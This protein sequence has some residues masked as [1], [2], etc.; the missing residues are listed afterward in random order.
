ME[1]YNDGYMQI[2]STSPQTLANALTDSP[3]GLL[4]WLAELHVK[5]ADPHAGGSTRTAC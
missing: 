1:A 2:Q 4:A 5:L 3:A